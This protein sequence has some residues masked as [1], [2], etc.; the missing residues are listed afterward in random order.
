MVLFPKV[1]SGPQLGQAFELA[2]DL[3]LDLRMGQIREGVPCRDGYFQIR[4]LELRDPTLQTNS[5]GVQVMKTIAT[6]Q[7]ETARPIRNCATDRVSTHLILR[8]GS[9]ISPE[10]GAS[11][12]QPGGPGQQQQ[13]IVRAD[14]AQWIARADAQVAR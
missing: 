4:A 5:G 1:N 6:S 2:R 14:H 12:I 9:A 13:V 3:A 7:P 11:V 8:R 10:P